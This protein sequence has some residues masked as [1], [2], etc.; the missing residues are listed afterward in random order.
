MFKFKI[1]LY[2]YTHKNVHSTYIHTGTFSAHCTYTHVNYYLTIHTFFCNSSIFVYW[3][4][5]IR[6]QFIHNFDQQCKWFV[7]TQLNKSLKTTC[8]TTVLSIL[9]IIKFFLDRLYVI[10]IKNSCFIWCIYDVYL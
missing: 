10:L 6:F 1:L 8:N 4:I 5:L 9:S 3:P 2:V 7:F